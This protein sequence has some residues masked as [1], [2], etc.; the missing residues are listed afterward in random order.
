MGLTTPFARLVLW[1]PR[2]LPAVVAAVLGL[3]LSAALYLWTVRVEQGQARLEVRNATN[4]LEVAFERTLGSHLQVVRSIASFYKA[5]QEVDRQEFA[6]FTEGPRRQYPGIWMLAWAPRIRAADLKAHVAEAI[7]FKT[8]ADYLPRDLAGR[9]RQADDAAEFFPLQFV[10]PLE[11][12]GELLGLDL[13]LLPEYQLA[14]QRAAESGEAVATPPIKAGGKRPRLDC[15]VLVPVYA[16]DQPAETPQ[17]RGRYLA[18]LAVGVIRAEPLLQATLSRA[19]NLPATVRLV[20][21]DGEV[22]AQRGEPQADEGESYSGELD[23]GGYIWRLEVTPSAAWAPARST[24]LLIVAG[25]LLFTLVSSYLVHVLAS[26]A[27]R[28]EALVQ[29]RTGE[30]LRANHDLLRS[31]IDRERALESLNQEQYLLHSLM[32]NHPDIIFFKDTQ[33]RF[34]RIN[35][36]LAERLKLAHPSEA[37]GKT[38]FD[39]FTQPYA[40]AAAEDERQI[41]KTGQ[42]LV[43]REEC[44]QSA[45]GP[46]WVS[47][48]KLPLRSAAG[49]IMG[50]FGIA[51]DISERKKAELAMQKAKE[52]AEAASRAK[53]DFLANMSHEIRTPMNAILGMTELLLDTPLSALQR[54]Y[55]GM[56]REAGETLLNVINDVLDFSKIEA[57]KIDLEAIDFELREAI[58]DILKVLAVRAHRKGLEL[59]CHVQP[60]VPAWLRGDPHRLAQILNNLVGNAIKFTERGEV[61]VTVAQATSNNGDHTLHFSVRDTGIGIPPDKRQAIFEAFEQADTSTSRRYGGTG[62][63]LAITRKLVALLGGTIWVESSLGHGSTFHFTA[64]FE[65]G[66]KGEPTGPPLVEHITDTRI[67]V[68]DDNATNR[69]ILEETLRSWRLNP[70]V[71]ADAREA[72]AKVRDARAQGNPFHVVLTDGRMPDVDGFALAE[73]IKN[74]GPVDA[75]IIMMLSSS[76]R[77]GD[78]RR[79]EEIGIACHLIKPIKPSELFNA[80][81]KALGVAIAE[82]EKTA[83]APIPA[84]QPLRILLAEDSLTN[85]KLACGLLAKQG[86]HVVTANN[87]RLALE[88]L[89]REPFELVLMDVQMP[90]LD[91]LE[92]TRLLRQREQQRGKGE[93]V[94]VIAMTAHALKGDREICLSAGMDDYVAKPIRATELFAAIARTV[95]PVAERAPDAAADTRP[96][97]NGV[98]DWQE[99]L[100]TTGGDRGLLKEVIDV[101][102]TEYPQLL[103]SLRRGVAEERCD[104][105]RRAAHTL[106]STLGHLGAPTVREL[107]LHL[108]S[109]GRQKDLNGAAARLDELEGAMGRVVA[110]LQAYTP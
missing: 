103:A 62:L 7:K 109:M 16:N 3:V 34:L 95:G 31:S 59:A 43:G 17:Q 8:P 37:L 86:H 72:L 60:S 64:R 82:P 20:A 2:H 49:E 76:D 69:L 74:E 70:V 38:D 65:P 96:A 46:I 83:V 24:S 110:A 73:S 78:L 45:A 55:L 47:T 6:D 56:V 42:P 75:T 77:P 9:P 99:A 80:L 13:A 105:V 29:Q 40:Q 23:L 27:R 90:E 32:T 107:A 41:M 94:P 106:K 79:C 66:Q 88:A 67:L 25:G 48:T 19:K 18:G 54:D 68:V 15:L 53:G 10:E 57:G 51:R 93:H 84:Q 21:A 89:E 71:C 22:L 44:E 102:L 52:A 87:G 1:L 101:F 81:V 5:S 26:R 104:D 91:G 85:Q 92:A 14:L 33:G 4:D 39:F 28:V 35:R 30:L 100:N 12:R 98:I 11:T 61:V 63:G 108:E 36:A 58:G 50:T 97:G